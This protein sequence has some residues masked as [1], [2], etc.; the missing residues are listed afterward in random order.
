[1]IRISKDTTIEDLVAA[2]PAAI[3]YL[4][5]KGVRCILCGEP[6]WGT[7]EQAARHKGK[8]DEQIAQIVSDL[9]TLASSGKDSSPAS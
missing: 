1:V 2:V 9:N 7:L 4:R 6:V 3:A 8:D 5:D